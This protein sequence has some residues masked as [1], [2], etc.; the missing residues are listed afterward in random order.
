MIWIILF[1]LVLGGCGAF[2]VQERT[3]SSKDSLMYAYG[4]ALILQQEQK[5][6][7]QVKQ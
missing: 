1:S 5:R 3:I 6:H 2:G 7:E 4:Q